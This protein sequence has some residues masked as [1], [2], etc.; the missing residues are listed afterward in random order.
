[1]CSELKHEGEKGEK[2]WKIQLFEHLQ[3]WRF[4]T[5]NRKSE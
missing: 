3:K 5:I 4:E 2:Q 1:M